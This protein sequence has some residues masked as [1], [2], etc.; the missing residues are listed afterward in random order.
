[1][2]YNPFKNEKLEIKPSFSMFSFDQQVKI[3]PKTSIKSENMYKTPIFLKYL[4]HCFLLFLIPYFVLIF[5]PTHG[6]NQI[7]DGKLK[8]NSY[9]LFFFMLYYGYFYLSALQIKYGLPDKNKSDLLQRGY[10]QFQGFMFNVYRIIP[11]LYEFKLFMD[12]YFT[13]TALSLVQWIK[14]EEISCRLFLAKCSSKKFKGR[15]HGNL[16]K[17][18]I[19]FFLGGCSV[20]LLVLCIFGPM[21][22]F[23][24][25]NPIAESNLVQQFSMKMG[26]MYDERKYFKLFEIE[27]VVDIKIV[28]DTE[29]EQEGFID[30]PYLEGLDRNE[31]Q[32]TAFQ[33]YSDNIW[34]ISGPNLEILK[35][36]LKE[37]ISK[38]NDNKFD[39]Q[40]DYSIKRQVLFSFLQKYDRLN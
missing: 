28:N 14:L 20:F 38:E 11:F 34:G 22:L 29:F 27:N 23:S 32:R 17:W 39:L 26:I 16:V 5:I 13:E 25:L 24:P 4:F 30:I 1:M 18:W 3:H 7:K 35:K 15:N 2:L 37:K 36:R 12:W 9:D 8:L 19:K 6:S 21:L 10:S 33:S 40:I 31:F